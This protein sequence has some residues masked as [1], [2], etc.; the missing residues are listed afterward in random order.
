MSGLVENPE[1]RFS[2]NEAQISLN[3]TSSAVDKCTR[4]LVNCQVAAD[5]RRKILFVVKIVAFQN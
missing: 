5:K 2:H 4:L 1:D 3:V